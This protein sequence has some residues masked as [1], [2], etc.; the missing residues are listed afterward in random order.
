MHFQLAQS[1]NSAG[2]LQQ[3]R[4]VPLSDCEMGWLVYAVAST[5]DLHLLGQLSM[6]SRCV[7]DC[8]TDPCFIHELAERMAGTNPWI[9]FALKYC[10]SP[11]TLKDI[12]DWMVVQHTFARDADIA[13]EEDEQESDGETCFCQQVLPCNEETTGSGGSARGHRS[14]LG[15]RTQKTSAPAAYCTSFGL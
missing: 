9:G 10:Q 11:E 5:Q 13:K 7:R 4:H 14:C 2:G 3:P 15:C 6:T 8:L 1:G 12:R